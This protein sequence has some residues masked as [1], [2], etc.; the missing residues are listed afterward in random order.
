MDTTTLVAEILA[1]SRK[2]KST[3]SRESGIS[4]SL[5]DGYLKGKNSPTMGQLRRLADAAGYEINLDLRPKPR[6]MPETLV[7]VLEF[8]DLFPQKERTPLVNLGPV[9]EQARNRG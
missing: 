9:W 4:R 3:L 5:L 6:P 7:H 2:S 1:R 8:G